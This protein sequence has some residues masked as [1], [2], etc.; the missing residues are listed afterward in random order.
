[1]IKTKTYYFIILILILINLYHTSQSCGQNCILFDKYQDGHIN[2]YFDDQKVLHISFYAYK[3]ENGNLGSPVSNAPIVLKIIYGDG[4][5]TQV[6]YHTIV[7]NSAGEAT[8][9]LGKL[10]SRL[11]G[12]INIRALYCYNYSDPCALETC[13]KF[14]GAPSYRDWYDA[15]KSSQSIQKPP[16]I[17]IAFSD[18]YYI[19]PA[20]GLHVPPFCVLGSVVLALVLGGAYMVGKN[21][22]A[23]FDLSTPHI[24]NVYSQYQALGVTTYGT[25]GMAAVMAVAKVVLNSVAKAHQKGGGKKDLSAKA[26]FAAAAGSV[27][28]VNLSQ[29]VKTKTEKRNDRINII[30]QANEELAN[31][32]KAGISKNT[33]IAMQ[34]LGRIPGLNVVSSIYGLKHNKKM[35][36]FAKV[37][38][39][40]AAL[41]HLIR[42]G[43]LFDLLNISVMSIYL[44]ASKPANYA[45][46]IR[47]VKEKKGVQNKLDAANKKSTDD[48]NKLDNLKKNNAPKAE[49]AK[50]QAIV[51]ADEMQVKKIKT[52]L[53][54]IN[55]QIVVAASEIN[56]IS[57]GNEALIMGK[58]AENPNMLSEL[59]DKNVITQDGINKNALYTFVENKYGANI[60]KIP[61]EH[62]YEQAA[63]IIAI[64]NSK[65]NVA[66]D[67]LNNFIKN[68][69]EKLI[70]DPETGK[71][72]KELEKQYTIEYT[73]QKLV[74]DIPEQ[75]VHDY[76][77]AGKSKEFEKMTEG[78]SKK[79]KEEL[80]QEKRNEVL[81]SYGLD[82]E[83]VKKDYDKQMAE[84]KKLKENIDNAKT[85]EE[86]E[87]AEKSFE[88]KFNETAGKDVDN[89]KDY[90]YDMYAK[91][92]IKVK[93]EE[94]LRISAINSAIKQNDKNVG[95]LK[96]KIPL[97]ISEAYEK[98]NSFD[99]VMA[100]MK[101]YSKEAYNTLLSAMNDNYY[102]RNPY[103]FNNMMHPEYTSKL[104]QSNI[105]TFGRMAAQSARQTVRSP[106]T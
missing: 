26:G 55:G 59:V 76:D 34:I 5:G 98:A 103:S 68:N 78:L 92:R 10:I 72:N 15:S 52:E 3:L 79:E 21:P 49:I 54:R 45:L 24:N 86:K 61:E 32:K 91:E 27:L 71:I 82:P 20:G 73:R 33:M 89:L 58:I 63:N 46:L 17:K 48:K 51:N 70:I 97:K 65:D 94:S 31:A 37:M 11:Q 12:V 40:L 36:K 23:M 28:G 69:P 90:T 83:N 50:Q 96:G 22:L 80:A 84:L 99:N 57:T 9:N 62:R 8:Y 102:A 38:G 18:Y 30:K 101:K 43:A 6:E 95:A 35:S 105:S 93:A 88:D 19:I 2:L 85:P 29:L 104:G 4:G 100:N 41:A 13:N 25:S 106:G 39:S 44:G 16:K 42:Y 66:I 53:N 64:E 75:A 56:A 67:A 87:K 1:M 81:S 7:T 74:G 60:S 14:L 47:S 77:S